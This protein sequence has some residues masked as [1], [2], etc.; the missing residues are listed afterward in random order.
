MSK[1]LLL[2]LSL[3]LVS[4]N[5][6]SQSE[7]VPS[8]HPVYHYLLRQSM[9]GR[10]GG[11]EWSMLPLARHEVA[12]FLDSLGRMPADRAVLGVDKDL[13][14]QYALEF[15]YDIRSNLDRSS[16]LLSDGDFKEIV[17]DDHRHYLYAYADSLS[18]IFIDGIGSLTRRVTRG[19]SLGHGAA[20]LGE[21][22]IRFRGTLGHHLG[23][24]LQAVN[25]ALMSGAHSVA[26][27]DH[28]LLAN[29]KFNEDERTFYDLTTGYLRYDADWISVMAGRDQLMWGPGYVERLVFSDN[30][31]PFDFFRLDFRSKSVHYSFLH[32]SLV[33]ADSLGH[34]LPSKYIAAHRLEFS[35]SRY[36][37]IAFSE[38][39]IYANQPM[40][41]A[42][43]NPF[44][45]MT[46]AELSTE[47][48]NRSDDAHNSLMWVDVTVKPM[49]GVRA[50]G[51]LLI[52]DLKFSA[53][54]KNDIGTGICLQ[55]CLS[56]TVKCGQIAGDERR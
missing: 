22:G 45:F 56:L 47:L 27:L 41:F 38:A 11:F 34:T 16:S 6:L 54:G 25:G 26:V 15:S 3:L 8:D 36:V 30:T 21:L 40:N 49:E 53:I 29:R 35:A 44:T 10:I 7:Y 48:A 28:R 39:V 18:A 19:D 12:A 46:S 9:A 1:T 32:G 37:Q 24:S 43:A 23:F 52:D 42:L 14:A 4:G 13:L 20:T 33:G 51:S 31:V 55:S 17:S 5:L 2:G 50:Y